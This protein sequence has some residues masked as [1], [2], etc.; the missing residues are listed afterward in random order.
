MLRA[1]VGQRQID[2][3]ESLGTV[4]YAYNNQ[5]T[6]HQGIRHFTYAMGDIR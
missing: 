2:G 1:Y 6:A 5:S 3:D 4:E